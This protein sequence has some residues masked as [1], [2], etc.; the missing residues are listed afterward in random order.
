MVLDRVDLI[1]LGLRPRRQPLVEEGREDVRAVAV[2][3]GHQVK[4]EVSAG[5]RRS[6]RAWQNRKKISHVRS[7]YIFVCL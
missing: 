2:H 3:R 7:I 6:K 4:L 5:R 1:V